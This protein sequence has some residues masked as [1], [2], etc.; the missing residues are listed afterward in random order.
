LGNVGDFCFEV[1]FR[2]SNKEITRQHGPA[3]GITGHTI[4]YH[5]ASER[6]ATG[7]GTGKTPS[8]SW[9]NIYKF[10]ILNVSSPAEVPTDGEGEDV[11]EK[12]D[13]EGGQEV[14]GPEA[15]VH[16]SNT[17]VEWTNMVNYSVLVLVWQRPAEDV[18]AAVAEEGDVD[19]ISQGHL[20]GAG[21]STLDTGTLWALGQCPVGHK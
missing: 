4:N 13:G 12:E 18:Q 11:E 7:P 17:A 10:S 5:P 19:V 8:G 9:R 1:L 2:H 16:H 15:T 14:V 21:H 20:G 3:P 6:R